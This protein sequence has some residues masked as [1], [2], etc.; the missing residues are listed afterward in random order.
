[1]QDRAQGPSLE[2][3]TSNPVHAEAPPQPTLH[4][5]SSGHSITLSLHVLPPE[6]DTVHG[7]PLGQ[8]MLSQFS[9]AGV[10]LMT[11]PK[12]ASQESQ[13]AGQAVIGAGGDSPHTGLE[14]SL[15]SIVQSPAQVSVPSEYPKSE[16]LLPGGGAPSHASPGSME[17]LPHPP[18]VPSS[19]VP[20][21]VVPGS[22]VPEEA[23]PFPPVV[24][25]EVDAEGLSTP[26]VESTPAVVAIVSGPGPTPSSDSDATPSDPDGAES[27]PAS[28][29]PPSAVPPS[30][31]GTP[32]QTPDNPSPA[33]LE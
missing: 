18:A 14:Q 30:A 29:P 8:L 24:V 7:Q 4:A 20:G 28:D 25:L 21:S 16:Q 31:D 11:Q 6:H 1:M 27:R 9:L 26:P 5:N 15:I 33:R 32:T 23:E 22:V 12:V 3:R 19:V 10:Q 17:P 13:P 2:Q